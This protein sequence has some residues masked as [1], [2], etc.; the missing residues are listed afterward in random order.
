[1]QRVQAGG[2]QV[3]K[4][5][6]DFVVQEALAGSGLS[7]NQFWSGY[8]A[9]LRDLA[10]RNR[11]LLHKRD[12]LQTAIDSWHAT[13]RGR[14][15]IAAGYESFLRD[16]GYLLPEPPPFSIG[17]QNVDAEI[18]HIAGPQLV[19]PISNARYA[20]NAAN[21]RWGSLYDALY[22][23][24]V[25]PETDG[26]ERGRGYNKRRGAK[27]VARAR[28]FLDETVKLA[29]GSHGDALGY[30]VRDGALRIATA[31]GETM[32]AD[33]A[34]CVG[35]EGDAARPTAVV[36]RQNRLHI[37]LKIDRTH[38]I[39]SEDPAGI[40]DV[41]LESA[42]STIMDCEDSV[43]AVDAEDK[44]LVYRWRH[45]DLAGPQ[46]DAGAQCRPSYVYRCGAGAGR[47]G[48]ARDVPGLRGDGAD[49][50]A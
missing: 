35:Y 2:L 43:A 28:A 37:V 1:M 8:A 30:S 20:L 26:A 29:H 16:I 14:G 32:L 49:R 31:T 3:A 18:A 50:H 34:Q 6:Y 44:V 38:P 4:T 23:T 42:V 19:V 24:D 17:T 25:I 11:A 13:N 9:L 48:N 27:V 36:L 39:G 45:A 33:P 10:P 12:S 46:P 21:A 41:V 15:L 5:L 7:A 22:G 47:R 40:C